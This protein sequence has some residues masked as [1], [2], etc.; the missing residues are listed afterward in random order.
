[1][2]RISKLYCLRVSDYLIWCGFAFRD[3]LHDLIWNCCSSCCALHSRMSNR[4]YWRLLPCCLWTLEIIIALPEL[5]GCHLCCMLHVLTNP[6]STH[7]VAS[8]GH[9]TDVVMSSYMSLGSKYLLFFRILVRECFCFVVDAS[10]FL[11][12]T[13]KQPEDCCWLWSFWEEIWEPW[14]LCC[15][16]IYLFTHYLNLCV[17]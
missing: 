3:D 8:M 16:I 14:W 9:Y 5:E 1:M 15:D 17:R 13:S 6:C 10:F 12:Q 11:C 7:I 2:Y 4:I